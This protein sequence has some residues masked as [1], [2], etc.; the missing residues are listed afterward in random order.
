MCVHAHVYA[1]AQLPWLV[2][3]GQRSA[4]SVT[5]HLPACL[6]Q[7]L[8]LFEVVYARPIGLKSSRDPS[9]VVSSLTV[10]VRGL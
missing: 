4:L 6:R 3:E 8:F 2:C 1:D 10:R 7:D 5:C 9:V